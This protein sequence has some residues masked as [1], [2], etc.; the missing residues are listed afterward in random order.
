MK[1]NVMG[2]QGG[3]VQPDLQGNIALAVRHFAKQ[4][5]ISRLKNNIIVRVHHKV[6]MSDDGTQALCESL[7]K[8][9]FIIDVSMY[10]NWVVNLAH[11]MVHVKQFALGEL[12]SGL[13]SWKSNKYCANIEY[14]DQPWEKEARRL[15]FK[16]AEEFE[17]SLDA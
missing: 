7:D 4:L 13:S 10:S 8:R 3:I 16:L 2:P 5:G 1:V 17:K 6:F 11:E 15:Q 12:D 14:W 9:N